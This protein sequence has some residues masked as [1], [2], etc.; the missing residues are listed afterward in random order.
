VEE[1]RGLAVEAAIVRVM[2]SRKVLNYP[3]L[4]QEVLNILRQFKPDPRVFSMLKFFNLLVN[5]EKD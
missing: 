1:D 5:K 4:I 2:K 3:N